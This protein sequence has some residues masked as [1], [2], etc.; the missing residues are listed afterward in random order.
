MNLQDIGS[1]GELIGAVAVIFSLVYLAMQIRQNTKAVRIQTYQAIM[2]SSN[3]LGDSMAERNFDAIYRKGRKDPDSCSEEELAQFMLIAGQVLNLY[4]GL[5]LHH[6]SGAIDD[7]FF[8]NRW[9]TF[10]RIMYQPGF[11]LIWERASDY[12][13]LSFT[14]AVDRLMAEEPER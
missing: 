6:Q 12:Y 11:R 14:S 5:Y 13:A 10:H 1:I 3:R 7:D 2:D 8:E 4:E 9:K